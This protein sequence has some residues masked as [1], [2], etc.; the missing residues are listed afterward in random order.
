MQRFASYSIFRFQNVGHTLLMCCE[1]RD[2]F[3]LQ[4]ADGYISTGL[5][6]SEVGLVI[7]YQLCCLYIFCHLKRFFVVATYL[8]MSC[9]C[10]P[11]CCF[12]P[13]LWKVLELF[14]CHLINAH[15]CLYLWF[16]CFEVA[17]ICFSDLHGM[18]CNLVCRALHICMIFHH[19]IW[20]VWMFFVSRLELGLFWII[21]VTC[22]WKYG[23]LICT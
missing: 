4:A 5:G 12:P 6:I 2:F 3:S 16:N 14:F 18:I 19:Y 20:H 7:L 9:F 11:M 8:K 15:A 17:L 1:F 23:S 21:H 22:F 13:S 10:T